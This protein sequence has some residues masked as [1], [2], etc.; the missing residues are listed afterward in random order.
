MEAATFAK[1][2]I[3]PRPA[4][5]DLKTAGRV[6]RTHAQNKGM[7]SAKLVLDANK[8]TLRALAFCSSLAGTSPRIFC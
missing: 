7:D 6:W 1:S 4:G 2:I 5:A 8:A 3:R